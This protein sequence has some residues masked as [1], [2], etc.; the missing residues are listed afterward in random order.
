MKQTWIGIQGGTCAGKTTL[1]LELANRLGFE[2]S[3][4]ICLDSFFLQYD[5]KANAGDVTAYNFDHPSSVDWVAVDAAVESLM[6]GTSSWIPQFDYESGL[7]VSGQTV[8]PKRYMI[9]EGLWPFCHQKLAKLFNLRVFVE[10]PADLRLVRLLRRNIVEGNRGW[11]IQ[12][13]LDYYLECVRPMQ[14]EFVDKGRDAATV[15]VRGECPATEGVN[16]IIKALEQG[17][18]EITNKSESD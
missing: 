10:A 5:R 1:A 9:I 17:Q 13:V 15:I 12:N 8:E 14:V 7:T 11:T 6:T 18:D 16:S 2:N 4:V 3:V